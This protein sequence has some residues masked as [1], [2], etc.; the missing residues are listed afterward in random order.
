MPF[1]K[2]LAK[3]ASEKNVILASIA[4]FITFSI[5][6]RTN[7]LYF[8]ENALAFSPDFSTV[9][10]YG[11]DDVSAEINPAILAA[12]TAV[13]VISIAAFGFLESSVTSWAVESLG[14]SALL[15]V[16]QLPV[17]N[18]LQHIAE[19]VLFSAA[20]LTNNSEYAGLAGM[21]SQMRSII[22]IGSLAL[23]AISSV[24]FL[25]TWFT[26]IGRDGRQKIAKKE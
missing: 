8:P 17:V 2:T 12:L 11:V 21:L 22:A 4:F 20:L 7:A 23:A 14:S 13:N 18:A 6:K 10:G 25:R 1:S 9:F 26:V 3:A 19:A 5:L 24:Q 15:V 16:N